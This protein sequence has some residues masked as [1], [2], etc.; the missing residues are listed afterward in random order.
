[1]DSSFCHKPEGKGERL[2]LGG[3]TKAWGPYTEV[4]GGHCKGL[5][6]RMV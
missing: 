4:T 3:H 1:M 5:S 6:R 2:S